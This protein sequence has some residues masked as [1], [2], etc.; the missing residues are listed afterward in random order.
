MRQWRIEA[1]GRLTLAP[2]LRRRLEA[3]LAVP[4]DEVPLHASMATRTG[5]A[6]EGAAFVAPAALARLG[7]ALLAHECA[8]AVQQRRWRAGRPPCTTAAAEAEARAAARAWRLGGTRRIAGALDPREPAGWG[9]GGHYYT[10]YFAFLAAGVDH[11]EA[12]KAAFYTQLPDEVADLDAVRAGVGYVVQ[13]GEKAG[14]DDMLPRL[15]EQYGYGPAKARDPFQNLQ[16]QQGLHSLTGERA[17]LETLKRLAIALDQDTRTIDFGLA[18]HAFGDSFAHRKGEQ[19]YAAPLGHG[20]DGHEPDLIGRP[21]ASLYERYVRLLYDIAVV[22]YP[23]RTKRVARPGQPAAEGRVT[24]DECFEA[25]QF[26]VSLNEV[27]AGEAW[28]R[29][30]QIPGIREAARSRLGIE[31]DAYA[32]EAQEDDWFAAGNARFL[33]YLVTRADIDRGLRLAEQWT[34]SAADICAG[35]GA[36]AFRTAEEFMRFRKAF[37]GGPKPKLEFVMPK[38]L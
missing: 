13:K 21:R 28:E 26:A 31:L 38:G 2:A 9:E 7:P 35:S 19:M 20:P 17:E 3:T 12:Q 25:L 34:A 15:A 14:F 33:P 30:V 16:V 29:G 24:A 8:H 37:A 27:S 1:G 36:A 32:P 5:F 22:K 23:N 11:G 18:L 4:L 6:V 10:V